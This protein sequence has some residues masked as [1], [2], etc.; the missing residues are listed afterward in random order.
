MSCKPCEEARKALGTVSN[1]V[2]GYTNLIVTDPVI[3]ELSVT[4]MAICLSCEY[5][6][7]LV[8]ING[9]QHY[10]C[11]KCNCPLDAATRAPD[12][13]CPIGKW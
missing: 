11:S 8:A 6:K 13:V 9:V 2:Q 12:K 10:Y 7:D 4:R 5:R 1:I 3:E